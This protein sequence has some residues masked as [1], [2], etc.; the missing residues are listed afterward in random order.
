MAIT[1]EQGNKITQPKV[2]KQ[3]KGI[4]LREIAA[5]KAKTSGGKRCPKCGYRIRS[6]NHSRGTHHRIVNAS[7]KGPIHITSHF[8]SLVELHL[9]K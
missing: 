8:K 3:I 7:A 9:A 2:R 1:D 6:V 5:N 4:R